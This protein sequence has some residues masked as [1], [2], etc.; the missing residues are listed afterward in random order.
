[1]DQERVKL[2]KKVNDKSDVLNIKADD[3]IKKLDEINIIL[4]E[5]K[6]I[7]DR[8]PERKEGWLGGYWDNS[9]K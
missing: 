9:K 5:I 7:V 8:L 4:K 6:E 2:L 1:M 3:T